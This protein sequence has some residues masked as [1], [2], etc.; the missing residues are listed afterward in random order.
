[1][2]GGFATEGAEVALGAAVAV[3][4][5]LLYV[6]GYIL[7]K[8]ALSALPSLPAHPLRLWRVCA[9]SPRWL[10]GFAI[11][12]GGLA[13]QVIA[14][15][16]AP[17]TVVQPILAAGVLGVAAAGRLVLGERLGQRER[18]ALTLVV[19]AVAAIAVSA[20]PGGEVAS[21]AA[22]ERF[23]VLA[24]PV[25]IVALVLLGAAARRRAEPARAPA[26]EG[27]PVST[28]F[29]VTG[30]SVSLR[31]GVVA[32]AAAAGLL[33]GIGAVAEKAVAARMVGSGIS[34]GA[35]RSLTT[36][37]P[38]VFVAATLVGMIAF[39]IGLQRH[40]ASTVVPLTNVLASVFVL[41]G[42]SVVFSERLLPAGWWAL[43]RL[44]GFAGVLAAVVVLAADRGPVAA[45]ALA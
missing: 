20:L 37:Y 10:A 45:P 6:V 15:T 29:G 35:V 33:Y 25:A 34:V 3:V 1:L 27:S 11:M 18:V 7:E 13:M 42:A 22:G 5:A 2:I 28:G 26:D 31:S 32:L 24:L 21:R 38:W 16:L 39:Q 43:P 36:A 40:H 23:V 19:V 44:T 12:L 41:A 30:S 9:R 17:V 4:S 8:Q 14:L